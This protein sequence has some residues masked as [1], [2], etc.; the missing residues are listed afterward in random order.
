MTYSTPSPLLQ[1]RTPSPYSTPA[2]YPHQH[3]NSSNTSNSHK[4][5]SLPPASTKTGYS[6][7]SN[8]PTSSSGKK[9]SSNSSGGGGGGDH[10]KPTP[11]PRIRQ[12]TAIA[13]SY[14]RR[15][16]VCVFKKCFGFFFFFLYI[17]I[18]FLHL[19]FF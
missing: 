12:R 11:G 19:F 14:C 8:N 17:I 7:L 15:R 10:N 4:A 16:K 6:Q 18:F 1:T 9:P 13:C 5:S 2:G 3:S